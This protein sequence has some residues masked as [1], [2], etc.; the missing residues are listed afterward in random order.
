MTM[1]IIYT[2]IY[3]YFIISDLCPLYKEKK[4]F[5]FNLITLTFSYLLLIFIAMGFKIPS[6]AEP[7]K[8]IITAMFG[9]E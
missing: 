7:I 3:I 8:N 2:I 6:P 9:K 5:M 1:I 4:N